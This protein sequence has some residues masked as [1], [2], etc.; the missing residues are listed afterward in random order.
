L[1]FFLFFFKISSDVKKSKT[2]SLGKVSKKINQ[3][4]PGKN[5]VKLQFN[6]T[7][8]GVCEIS[9]ILE[10]QNHIHLKFNELVDYETKNEIS[11]EFK[12]GKETFKANLKE[13]LCID[14][15]DVEE[16]LKGFICESGEKIAP[17]EIEL[18]NLNFGMNQNLTMKLAK[19]TNAI[20]KFGFLFL[21]F[22][23]F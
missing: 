1:V 10:L 15:R 5:E 2:E 22:L 12:S 3:L 18:E 6:S 4:K 9:V 8:G 16:P 13:K 20:L 14:I 17:L 21:K 23:I 7:V 11:F 19:P